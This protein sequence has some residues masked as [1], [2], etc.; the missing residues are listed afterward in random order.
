MWWT[1]LPRIVL[2]SRLG[3]AHIPTT[4]QARLSRLL[5]LLWLQGLL[6]PA[7][8]HL[9][10]VPGMRR[11]CTSL[12]R[13]SAMRRRAFPARHL[14]R[15]ASRPRAG[16]LQWRD[17]SAELSRSCVS[18]AV[19]EQLHGL[20]QSRLEPR[21]PPFAIVS[22]FQHPHPHPSPASGRGETNPRQR[23][24]FCFAI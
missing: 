21:L 24:P 20:R 14:W 13:M 12:W 19:H 2:A 16:R 10:P 3:L 18:T 17:C 23:D 11:T 9:L 5:S 7:A 22:D 6:R 1:R 15:A 8:V 4:V